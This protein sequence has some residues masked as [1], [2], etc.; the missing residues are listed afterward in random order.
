[1]ILV[2][3]SLCRFNDKPRKVH[4]LENKGSNAYTFDKLFLIFSTAPV[5]TLNFKEMKT[6]FITGGAGF[7][8]G[9]FILNLMKSSQVKLFDDKR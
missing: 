6:F 9:N 8:G 2:Q 4:Y 1:M 3:D 5:L 7:I